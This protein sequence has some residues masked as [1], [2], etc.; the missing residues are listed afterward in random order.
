MKAVVA[1]FIGGGLGSVLRYVFHRLGLKYLPIEF[2]MATLV[3]NLIST[4]ILAVIVWY[5][6]EKAPPGSITHT[7]LVIGFCGGFSTFSTFSFETYSLLKDNNY[8]IAFL[9]VFISIAF[10][11]LI[12]HLFLRNE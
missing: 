5:Y 12:L 1:V 2:P 9:N 6:A 4:L 11:L 3:S 10:A 8:F 7:L